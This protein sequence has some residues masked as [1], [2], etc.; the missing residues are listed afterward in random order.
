MD[1]T[2]WWQLL[3]GL[4][5][6]AAGAEG[7]VRGAS[8]LASRFGVPP[9]VIGLT[10]VAFGTSTPEMAVSSLAAVGGQADL[11]FGNVVG[12]NIFNVLFI[13]GLSALV[14]PLVV[15][16]RLVRL[17]VPVM[18]ATAL[19]AAVFSLDGTVGRLDG[20][21]LLALLAGYTAFQVGQ[22]R[23]EGAAVR[24]EF[25]QE[26]GP[27]APGDGRGAPRRGGWLRDAAFVA[28]GLGLLLVGSDLLVD[29]SVSLARALGLSELV[30]GLTVVAAGTSMPELVTSL[31]A[32]IRGER[33]I[34]VGNVV[35]SNIFNVLGVLGLSA[36]ISP[37][38][39]PVPPSALAFDL[40][41]M[42]AACL[43]CLPIFFTGR[44]I[45]RWEGALFLGYGLA[46]MVTLVLQAERHDALAGWNGVMLGWALPL[47]AVTLGVLAWREFREGA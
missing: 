18:V 27:P 47:T 25:A 9:L 34:A 14:A 13:L 32:T 23:R 38:G 28:A 26:Y 17:D 44:R 11:A 35:G 41:V 2:T 24:A 4:A 6:L 10:V 39:V 16:S 30:I 45:A 21:L 3:G 20:L 22:A 36:A 40:P 8:R 5:A 37:R 19:L 29:G 1:P 33:D 46:W 31:V 12:S 43:A 15:D 7:L 42:L